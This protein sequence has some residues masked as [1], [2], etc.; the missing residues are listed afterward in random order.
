L[1]QS[2]TI[3]L[4]QPTLQAIAMKLLRCKADAEDVVQ[5][6]F[7]KW[8]NAEHE[9]IRNTKAYLIRSVTNNCLNHLDSLKKKKQEY[10]ES[11][12]WPEFIEKMRDSEFPNLD[13]EVK[14]AKA[15][16]VI[17]EKLEPLERAVYILKEFFD[18]DYKS[19]QELLDKKQD[20]CRQLVARARK[21]IGD[22]R[23]NLEAA[24]QPKKTALFEKFSRACDFGPAAE[25]VNHLRQDAA[26]APKKK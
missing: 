14:M 16:Q 9:K 4:Y 1:D 22:E 21:K 7:Y 5:E 20:H 17:Q 18:V 24:I 3:A 10:I 2:Q 8:L 13:L 15:I 12:Q 11:F 19:L 23:M 6:T 25:L 26:N